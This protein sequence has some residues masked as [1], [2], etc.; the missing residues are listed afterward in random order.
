MY[1][2][3]RHLLFVRV[4][5]NIHTRYL[6]GTLTLSLH[7]NIALFSRMTLWTFAP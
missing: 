6:Y 5:T 7:S 3:L 1:G 2:N 4:C